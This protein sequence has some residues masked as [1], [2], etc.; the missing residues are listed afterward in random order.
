MSTTEATHAAVEALLQS[1]FITF[2][3]TGGGETRQGDWACDQWNV[4][5]FSPLSRPT[6]HFPFYTGLGHRV[7]KKG[8]RLWPGEKPQATPKAPHIASVIHSLMLDSGALDESFDNWCD[9]FGYNSDSIKA[10]NTY[11]ECCELGKKFR[12][13]FDRDTYQQ[14][15]KLL[16]DY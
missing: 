5:M 15:S 3:I 2:K 1:K 12:P 13:L 6:I 4:Q 10:F 11:R 14:L 8:Q 16:E 9:N 7:V